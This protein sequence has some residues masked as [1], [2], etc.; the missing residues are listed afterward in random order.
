MSELAFDLVLAS[1]SPRRKQLLQQLGL[2]P[3]CFSVDI[4]ERQFD[5]ERVDDYVL[6]LAKQKAQAG[7]QKS[8]GKYPVLGADTVVSFNQQTLGKPKNRQQVRQTLSLLSG[9]THQVFSA[10]ALIWNDDCEVLCSV[11]EVTFGEIPESWLKAYA[12]SDEPMDKAGC[13]AIQG[14]A[15][16]WVKQICGSYSSVMGLPLFETGQLLCRIGFEHLIQFDE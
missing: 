7:W 5:N 16:M 1:A 14:R 10:V 13:Y 2:N 15:A 4:D 6:R 8:D 11:N 12:N 3:Y 9:Q